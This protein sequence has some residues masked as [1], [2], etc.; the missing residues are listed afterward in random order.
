[1]GDWLES[2]GNALDSTTEKHEAQT[3]KIRKHGGVTTPTAF[4]AAD[5]ASEHGSRLPTSNLSHI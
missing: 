4:I 5:G 1:M 2:R 3:Q